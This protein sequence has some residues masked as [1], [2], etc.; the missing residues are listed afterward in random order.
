[1]KVALYGRVSS[2]KQE[3]QETI[4]S[5]LVALRDYAQKNNY[6]I[7]EE[8]LDN[9]YSGELL[10]RPALD[11]L[12][13]DA[14]KKLFNAIL[15]HSP[16]R[17]ARK[18]IYSGLV[19]EELKKSEI[20]IIFLN[21]PD[22]KDTPEENLLSGIQG[23]IA[24]FEKAKILERTR[25]G[26]L[27][28]AKNGFLVGSIAPFGYRYIKGDRSK[29]AVGYYEIVEKETKT[30][31]LIFDLFVNKGLSV[32][33]V[34][35][36]LT[37]KGISP[38]KGA[39]K[40]GASSVHRII[41]NET[42]TGIAYYN[43]NVLVEPTNKDDTKYRR[44]RKTSHRLRPKNQW[45]PI[46]LPD[47]LIIIDKKTF[48]L[49][50]KQ[51]KRNSELSPRNVKY[52]YLLR[53][54]I[55]CGYCDSLYRGEPCHSVLYYRC[56]NR[57]RNFPLPRDCKAYM[58]KAENIEKVVWDKFCEAIK[59][60]RL[61]TEQVAKLK[62][63]VGRS[64]DTLKR[65]VK[66]IDKDIKNIDDEESRLLDAYREKVITMEQLKEQMAKVKERRGQLGEEKQKLSSKQE[67]SQS[68]ISS[69]STIKDYCK[70]IERRLNNVKDDFNGK[71]YLLSLAINKIS[72]RNKEVTIKG[73]IPAYPIHNKSVLPH[74]G[75]IASL[76]PLWLAVPVREKP[77]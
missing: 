26:K 14:K 24:E 21:R 17:L 7:H 40:W 37:Y 58:V 64:K 61:I 22:S 20:N 55:K 42:Y 54:L 38:R 23:L 10:A 9:G 6:T 46:K 71:R 3:K 32:R 1:M 73:I 69:K 16:D 68:L 34:V 35:R 63:K 72:L 39:K 15:I 5:Q 70:Q 44:A 56:S 28:K 43:K 47:N 31:R 77:C 33:G 48:D 29:N 4:G 62:E 67:S 27:H 50:Q 11:K 25:R 18:Y 12:R 51:L 76:I 53:G 8:Y 30:V 65:D 19:Q 49:A 59:N 75:N 57:D 2:E 52:N 74:S 41:R 13:D 60:P 66:A 45:I 36:E